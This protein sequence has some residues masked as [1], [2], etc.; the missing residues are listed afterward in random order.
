MLPISRDYQNL[1]QQF[2]WVMP[3]RFNFAEAISI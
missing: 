1:Y 3:K 2:E